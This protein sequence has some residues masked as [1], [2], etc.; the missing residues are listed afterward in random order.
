MQG[1]ELAQGFGIAR[2]M[3]PQEFLIWANDWKPDERWVAWQNCIA[4]PMAIQW[5]FAIVEHNAW[6][7]ALNHYIE[8]GYGH[9]PVLDAHLCRFGLWFDRDIRGKFD[10]ELWF[11]KIDSLH[12]QLHKV[13]TKV[14]NFS[15]AKKEKSVSRAMD[16]IDGIHQEM[17]AL[18]YER[19]YCEEILT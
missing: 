5:L 10:Q 8:E 1:C 18:L 11:E 12:Q 2:P 17:V 16:Q 19:I 7:K 6:V 9:P 13:G 4:S 3:P 15:L 14:V